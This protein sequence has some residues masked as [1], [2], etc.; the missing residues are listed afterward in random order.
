MRAES[1]PQAG[2]LSM[3]GIKWAVL[4]IQ[5]VTL[6]ESLTHLPICSPSKE[7]AAIIAERQNTAP[8]GG[9]H[10]IKRMM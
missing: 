2:V 10:N 3:G 8:Y 5:N 9:S 6:R 7:R 1:T 4:N